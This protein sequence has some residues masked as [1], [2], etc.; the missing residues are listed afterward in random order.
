MI[1]TLEE[2]ATRSGKHVKS[3]IAMLFLR[4]RTRLQVG[5]TSPAAI[6]AKIRSDAE[7]D[8]YR[9]NCMLSS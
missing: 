7:L 5:V 3:Q 1:L 2:P 4:I 8:A 6:A 9:G